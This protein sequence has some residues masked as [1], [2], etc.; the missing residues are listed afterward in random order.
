MR[1]T[2]GSPSSRAIIESALNLAASL[3]LVWLTFWVHEKSIRPSNL[4]IAYL[5]AKLVCYVLWIP[6]SDR[7]QG[8][9]LAAAQAF[10]TLIMLV[11]ENQ[12]KRSILLKAYANESPEATSSFLGNVLFLWINPI[13]ATGYGKFLGEDDIPVLD[14]HT[15]SKSLRQA[16]LRAWDQR[17]MYDR[18]SYMHI[19]LGI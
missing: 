6:I 7:H 1:L 10:S 4:V 11:L 12:N 15:S 3:G 9:V 13:L 17:G 5:L 19:F 16:M 14:Q 18:A 8:F 2:R